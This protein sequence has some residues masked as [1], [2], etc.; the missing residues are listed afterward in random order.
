M[1]LRRRSHTYFPHE[2]DVGLI[3]RGPTLEAAF[4]AAA[5]ALFGVMVDLQGVRPL[6]SV[7]VAFEED[8]VELALVTWLNELLSETRAAG[9]ALG[10][11]ELHRADDH[12]T[13]Q[14]WGEPWRA[15]LERGVEVKGATLTMLS[16]AEVDGGWEARCVVDV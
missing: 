6:A 2:A 15:D 3:G 5:E 1:V 16:V 12:W 8:D 7:R 9:L 13:G 11:F 14:A 4:E 10:R